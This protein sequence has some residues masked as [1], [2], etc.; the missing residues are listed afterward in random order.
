M[1]CFYVRPATKSQ[2][3]NQGWA[4]NLSTMARQGRYDPEFGDRRRWETFVE[5]A[6]TCTEISFPAAFSGSRMAAYM[7]TCREQRWLHI[8]HQMWRHEDVHNSPNHALTYAVTQQAAADPELD[9]VCYGYVPLCAGARL[10]EYKLRFGYELI[11]HRSAIQLHPALGILSSRLGRAALR[12]VRSF[13]HENQ[14]L[15]TIETVLEGASASRPGASLSIP[16]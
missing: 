1:E 12:A 11:S 10:H 14:Q 8:L 13:S 4:L 6:F 2:V 16:S 7:V 9:A 5:A 15:Q 3:L